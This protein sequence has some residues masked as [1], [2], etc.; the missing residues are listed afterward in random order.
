MAEDVGGPDGWARRPGQIIRRLALLAG[1]AG[2]IDD[3][4][5]DALD[6]ACPYNVSIYLDQQTTARDLIQKIAASVNAVALVTWTGRLVVVPV[7]IGTAA[8]P[9]TWND[10]AVWVD[11]GSWQDRTVPLGG[12]PTLTLAADGSALPA[13]STVKQIAIDAPYQKLAIGAARAWTVY[14]LA[15]IA[16]EAPLVD[17]GRYDN[18]ETYREGNIVDLANGSRWLFI[19]VAPKAGV[20]PGTDGNEYW[21]NLSPATSAVDIAYEDGTPLEDLKPAEPGATAGAPAG[22][23]VGD[24]DAATVIAS[25]DINAAGILSQALRQDDLL[26]LLDA[27]TLVE[28]QAV[29]TTF[30][31][32]RNTQQKTNSA[33][34]SQLDLIG[35]KNADGTGWNLNL[36]SVMVGPVSLGDRFGGLDAAVGTLSTDLQELGAK[37]DGT[38]ATVTFLREALASPDGGYANALL[39][40]D[41]DGVF[42]AFAITVDGPQRL[43][44]IKMVADELH[45]VDPNNGNPIQ[46][47]SIVGGAVIA[48]NFQADIIT[49]GALVQRFTDVGQQHLDPAGW[50][51]EIPGGLIMMGGKYRQTINR[52]VQLTVSFPKPFPSQ[53]LS[54]GVV[55]HLNTY[56]SA[57]DLWLQTVG[58]PLLTSF[59]VQTQAA[60][61]DNMTLD[62]F[63]WWAWGK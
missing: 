7:A 23:R 15:D 60:S 14:Q 16:F 29:G 48:T 13:V 61:S 49:Y 5:L 12:A 50:Y 11:V 21:T 22:T 30:L 8:T 28:G 10:T 27:R 43:S 17:R 36:S 39:R 2:K 9:A 62:G 38:D 19:N 44:Q 40:A 57:R 45:F 47:F 52:E 37:Y 54:V 55:P 56:S 42:G 51:Q 18:A 33:L 63:D 41:A 53:V 31:S 46:P 25:L 26:L 6:A 3:A 32:F 34:A 35:A 59:S 4:S 24:R 58:E 1:G 20:V